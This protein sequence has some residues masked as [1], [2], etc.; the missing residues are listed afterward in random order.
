MES[1]G[2][3]EA[4][5]WNLLMA[6]ANRAHDDGTGIWESIP[7]L[8]EHCGISE[9][10]AWRALPDLLNPGLVID[11]G[12]RHPTKHGGKPT[13]EYRID[14]SKFP[15][16]QDETLGHS[17]GVISEFPRFQDDT[18]Q[19]VNLDSQGVRMTGKPVSEPVKESVKENSSAAAAA[20][21][22][23]SLT[24]NPETGKPGEG[25]AAYAK[26]MGELTGEEVKPPVQPVESVPVQPPVQPKPKT[27]VTKSP[28]VLPTPPPGEA[29]RF[30]G[31]FAVVVGNA[32]SP[33]KFDSLLREYPGCGYL[34]DFA[35]KPGSKTAGDIRD[36]G[37]PFGWLK[38]GLEK[39]YIQDR[40]DRW[41]EI[42]AK[43]S[44]SS[45]A[46][47]AAPDGEWDTSDLDGEDRIPRTP[48][49]DLFR[50]DSTKS[51]DT[52]VPDA[53]ISNG[54]I[55]DTKDWDMSS[56]TELAYGEEL[57]GFVGL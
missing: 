46:A 4:P 37:N 30:A 20:A 48:V 23:N 54:T 56:L 49:E 21:V 36:A 51:Q 6:M 25:W 7:N 53:K 2:C 39:G 24:G 8:A 31:M 41:Q 3:I 29:A 14:L 18:L 11:T 47:S 57:E 16:C 12:R 44:Q 43:H 34:L 28:P 55:V 26:I 19:G 27:S 15:R 17:Q 52:K 5:A 13:V 40:W 38:K 10:T 42:L 33:W 9:S 22:A 32:V 1:P 50:E 35:L 45:P